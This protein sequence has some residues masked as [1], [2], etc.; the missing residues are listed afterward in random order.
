MADKSD[1]FLL[2]DGIRLVGSGTSP[3]VDIEG[4]GHW[5]LAESDGDLRIGDEENMLK[6]GVALDGGGRGNASIW[7][8]ADLKL[9]SHGTSVARIN[10]EG[11]HPTGSDYSLAPRRT[12]GSWLTCSFSGSV[13]RSTRTSY[14]LPR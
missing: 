2:Q 12:P 3:E 13:K 10:S 7:A 4:G 9:G 1:V 11:V 5:N 14:R 6:M 8:T